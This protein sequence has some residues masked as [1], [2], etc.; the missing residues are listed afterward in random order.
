MR[1]IYASIV[2]LFGLVGA[3]W[4]QNPGLVISEFLQNPAGTDSPLEYVEL[5]ATDDIDFTT[6]P[7]TVIVL[8]NGTATTDG[9]VEGNSITYAF[10]ITT[11]TVSVG[12]VVYVGGTGMTP[13]GTVLRAIDTGVDGGDGGIGNSSSGGVFGN[14][15]GNG[16]GIGIFNLP[17]G[18]ITSSTAPVDAVFYGSGLG[19]AVVGGVCLCHVCPQETKQVCSPSPSFG[20]GRASPNLERHVRLSCMRTTRDNTI[21]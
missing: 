15:G 6:T 21:W 5:L 2:A 20:L 13:T 17:V 14:G 19:G 8:N 16:D 3:G 9:W 4:A 7:Y 12:D 1:K 18:S 10:E 11:G